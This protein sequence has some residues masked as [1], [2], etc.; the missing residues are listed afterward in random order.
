[1]ALNRKKHSYTP[2]S[3]PEY[4]P[5]PPLSTKFKYRLDHSTA[6]SLNFR[7]RCETHSIQGRVDF[8]DGVEGV[9][10][11]RGGAACL[12]GACCLLLGGGW[13]EQEEV[14]HIYHIYRY[15][16]HRHSILL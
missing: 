3:P 8:Y 9:E 14:E 4:T 10:A 11:R 2:C 7:R 15:I 1:M 5:V 13:S 6:L 16:E 12:A